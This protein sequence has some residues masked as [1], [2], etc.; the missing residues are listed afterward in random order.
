M[1][2]AVAWIEKEVPA[3]C[4]EPIAAI[5]KLPSGPEPAETTTVG[6]LPSSKKSFPLPRNWLDCF[7]T[8]VHEEVPP[9]HGAVPTNPTFRD[10]PPESRSL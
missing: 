1:S 2:N 10:W 5:L 4:G 7:T 3:V 8:G 6:T 9:V